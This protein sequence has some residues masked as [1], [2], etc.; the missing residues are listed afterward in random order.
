MVYLYT[1]ILSLVPA[2]TLYS[3]SGVP[4]QH[5]YLTWI[6]IA[7]IIGIFVFIIN[8]FIKSNQKSGVI[9]ASISIAFFY[10]GVFL[11]FISS[12]SIALGII[13]KKS[14][15]ENSTVL[16]LIFFV[17]WSIFWILIVQSITRSDSL[18]QKYD[19]HIRIVSIILFVF[20]VSEIGLKVFVTN[21]NKKHIES[22]LLHNA[23]LDPNKDIAQTSYDNGNTPDIYYLVFDGF[24]G[25]K[26]LL[27]YYDT[28]ILYFIKQ[29][30]KRG[31]YIA[32]E[33]KSNYS[34]TISS[35][36]SSLNINY[37]DELAKDEIKRVGWIPVM[38]LLQDSLVSNYLH[39][40]GYDLVTFPSGFW[41][42]ED[43]QK[44][45][46]LSPLINLNEYQENF[47]LY[48][49]VPRIF[50]S[51]LYD[52]HRNRINF[53]LSSL[54]SITK[55]EKPIFVFVHVLTPHPPFI[56]DEEGNSVY[57]QRP[58]NHFDA[59]EYRD[60]GGTIVEYQ[61]MSGR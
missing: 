2:V 61:E 8:F 41:P 27:E 11:Q 22:I 7:F 9:V 46:K 56:F 5:A 55:E 12:I 54:K 43:I 34:M 36:P 47:L 57:P 58:F 26:I 49:P 6:I 44:D 52:N 37:W 1:I 16:P 38:P 33:S 42:T 30:E 19:Y 50:P 51:I 60:L 48:T 31:M 35:L 20:M 18:T 4:I 45:M 14:V 24:A 25:P 40:I 28:D 17:I 10:F 3:S 13:Q 23:E 29:L 53:T 15:I 32:T 59:D 39:N 21:K